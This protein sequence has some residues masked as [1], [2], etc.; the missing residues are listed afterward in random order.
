MV[1]QPG[2]LA[3]RRLDDVERE[4]HVHGL[5]S[6]LATLTPFPA[7]RLACDPALRKR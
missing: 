1:E 4:G 3:P 5:R 2:F 7:G 6:L